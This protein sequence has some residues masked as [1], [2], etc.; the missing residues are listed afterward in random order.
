MLELRV[1]GSNKKSP[2]NCFEINQTL[3]A[4]QFKTRQLRKA[5]CNSATIFVCKGRSKASDVTTLPQS[6]QLTHKASAPPLKRCHTQYLCFLSAISVK[7]L[8]K[9]TVQEQ[10]KL[11]GFLLN[12][13]FREDVRDD[14]PLVF[15]LPCS[16]VLDLDHTSSLTE[17]VNNPGFKRS[18]RQHSW[19]VS[20][21]YSV[22]LKVCELI[23]L[24]LCFFF[25]PLDL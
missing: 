2:W 7:L 6:F 12:T 3:T 14:N 15:N 20:V 9:D 10:V 25:F 13:S 4:A 5:K 1:K 24:N 19:G 21:Y 18:P 22:H 16:S 11:S 23:T 17:V 8:E